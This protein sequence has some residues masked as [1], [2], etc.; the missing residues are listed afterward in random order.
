MNQAELLM[1]VFVLILWTFTITL[2]MAYGRVKFTKNPQKHAAHTK[3]LKG[4]LP[5]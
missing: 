5:A 3:D 2:I 1:P 4:I